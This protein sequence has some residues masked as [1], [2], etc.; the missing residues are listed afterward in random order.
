MS[1]IAEEIL[2]KFFV[3]LLFLVTVLDILRAKKP[4]TESCRE[5][6]YLP[7]L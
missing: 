7:C 6:C 1:K 3:L 2:I 4:N 5:K